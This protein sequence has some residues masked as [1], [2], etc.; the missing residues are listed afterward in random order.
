MSLADFIGQMDRQVLEQRREE[1]AAVAGEAEDVVRVMTIH[2]AKGL[3]FPVVVIPDL[4]AERR[5]PPGDLLYRPDWGLTYK[6]RDDNDDGRGEPCLSHRLAWRLERADLAA[7]DVRRLYVAVTRHRDHLVLVGADWRDAEGALR[8]KGSHL[9]QIDGVLGLSAAVHGGRAEVA[10]GD[11]RAVARRLRA[12]RRPPRRSDAAGP[13]GAAMLRAAASGAELAAALARAAEGQAADPPLVGPLAADRGR[14]ELA[15]TALADF[16]HCPMLY[17]WRHE[18]R[19]PEAPAGQPSGPPP[20][21]VDAATLGTLVHRCMELADFARPPAYESLVARAAAEMDLPEARLDALASEVVPMLRQVRAG[22]LG[23][24]LAAARRALRELD[25]IMDLG[26]LTLRGQIDLLLL[27]A[28]GTW[29]VVDYKSDRVGPEDLPAH[30]ERYRLQ[31]LLYA[32]AAAR[33]LGVPPAEAALHFLRPGLTHRFAVT[34]GALAAVEGQA[35]ALGLELIASRRAGRFGR[36]RPEAC[37]GCPYGQACRASE[38]P[39]GSGKS[40]V[41]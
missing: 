23:D 40:C 20:A 8:G 34:R 35:R 1:Q 17:R 4:N 32:A 16:Q 39:V 37:P 12:P 28:S 15:V 26:P 5:P 13:P 11:F 10:Y 2:A 30:A 27:D 33:H 41:T 38:S 21:G 22:P 6:L 14:V 24:A 36:R 9:E 29:H 18:L 19:M 7:E 3:E 25:F 31:V